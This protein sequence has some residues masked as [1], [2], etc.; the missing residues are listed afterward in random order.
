MVGDPVSPAAPAVSGDGARDLRLVPVA[1]M[2]WVGTGVGTS[3]VSWTWARVPVAVA[4]M[5]VA[6]VRRSALLL[7]VGLMLLTGVGVGFFHHRAMINSEVSRLASDEAI[8]FVELLTRTDAHRQA[9]RGPRPAYVTLRATVVKITG[10]GAHWRVRAPVLVIVSGEPV[11]AWTA[12]P[13]CTRL[14]VTAHLQQPTPGSDFA[15]VARIRGRA[16]ILE[17]PP[18][19]LRAVETVR[20]GLRGAVAG[21]SPEQRALVHALV[22]GVTSAMTPEIKADFQDTGLTLLTAVS[23]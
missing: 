17:V 10:R 18:A 7:A 6:A 16:T 21:R 15:A 4:L 8:V 22:L 5:A 1:T 14:R 13:V 23:G 2:A 19:G 9:A 12:T 3:G 20:A 11:E